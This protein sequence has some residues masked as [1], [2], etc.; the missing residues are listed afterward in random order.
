MRA[1]AQADVEEEVYR[2]REKGEEWKAR[3][4]KRA[5]QQLQ[6]N[7]VETDD[8]DEERS[9]GRHTPEQEELPRSRGRRSRG[10]RTC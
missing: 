4:L 9:A 3:R 2:L 8:Y 6:E 7:A 10:R 1:D 5:F